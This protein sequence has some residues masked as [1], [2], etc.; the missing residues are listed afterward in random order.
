VNRYKILSNEGTLY[1]IAA[2]SGCGKTSLV[3]A[4]VKSEE[5]IEI[6]VSHTTRPPRPGEQD[7]VDYNFVDEAAFKKMIDDKDFLEYAEVF[8][9]HYGTSREWIAETLEKGIDVILEIDWQGARQIGQLFHHV[10]PIFIIPPSREAL[11]KRLELRKQDSEE[12]I[13]GRMQQAIS[14]M[15][16]YNEFRYLIVND[17]FDRALDDLRCILHAERLKRRH[18]APKL[19]EL[20]QH[21]LS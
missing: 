17:D 3:H 15:T 11:Q 10:K 12:V 1:V 18:Q 6:S 21:L 7:G 8:G 9:H 14:E 19:K 20:L 5:G 4:L 2:P 16:H 13:Q